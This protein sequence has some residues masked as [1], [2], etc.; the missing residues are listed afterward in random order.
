V[1]PLAL[2]VASNNATHVIAGPPYVLN[3][4]GASIQTQFIS[5][6]QAMIDSFVNSTDHAPPRLAVE[7][8]DLTV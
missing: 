3:D 2:D 8:V 5:N 6:L 7:V 1:M 4:P